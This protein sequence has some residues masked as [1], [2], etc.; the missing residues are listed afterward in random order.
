MRIFGRLLEYEETSSREFNDPTE[1]TPLQLAGKKSSARR[2]GLFPAA[3]KRDTFLEMARSTALCTKL[4]QYENPAND[5]E[6]TEALGYSI[7]S[8]SP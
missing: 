4:G 3:A 2:L 1:R 7:V 6:M 5:M 8:V